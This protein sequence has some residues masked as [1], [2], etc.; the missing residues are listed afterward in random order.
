MMASATVA[1]AQNADINL[2]EAINLHRNTHLDGTFRFI[3]NTDAPVTIA[4]P[5]ASIIAGVLK[6]DH[7]LLHYGYESAASFLVNAVVT[8]ELKHMI[9]RPRP[10]ET[11]PQIQAYK[12]LHSFSFPSGHTSAAF[13]FATTVSLEYH[14]WY[15]VTGVYTYASLV[16]YSRMDLGVHYPS[17]VLAGILTGTGSTLLVHWAQKKLMIKHHHNG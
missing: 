1:N 8:Y 7:H 14:K 12:Q 16:A 13:S 15:V 6:K 2:L 9:H 5:C 17:D 4:V 11:F 10:S 3:S